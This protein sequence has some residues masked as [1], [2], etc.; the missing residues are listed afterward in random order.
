MNTLKV[1]GLGPGH[2]DYILPI[3]M[4]IIENSDILIG[5]KRHIESVGIK[6]KETYEIEGK[7]MELPT[8]IREHI[9]TRKM[10]V[11]VSGDTGF[12]SLLRF[13]KKKLPHITI[14]ATPG[15]SSMQYLF[16]KSG[17]AWDDAFIG[18]VHG[19]DLDYVKLC[20]E[21]TKLGMLTDQINTPQNIAN[22]LIE[23]GVKNKQMII[24]EH[25]S[26]ADERV[27]RMSL[28]DV[29][30]LEYHELN[31]IIIVDKGVTY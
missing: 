17:L 23:K 5:G 2:K 18:S 22:V 25:L 29:L 11:V 26:Y 16:S 20:S 12:Y 7:L 3:T 14:E 13:L 24:G 15:I 8:F 9:K 4:K 30:K 27:R 28:E 10:T 19:R 31:V 6:D 1:V 21:Y